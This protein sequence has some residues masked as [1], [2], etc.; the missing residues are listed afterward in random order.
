MHLAQRQMAIEKINK[1]S[2]PAKMPL[3]PATASAGHSFASSHAALA[4][5]DRSSEAVPYVVQLVVNPLRS[6]DDAH[7][8]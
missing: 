1:A 5:F 7:Q 2:A 4:M 3:T 8:Q 6:F